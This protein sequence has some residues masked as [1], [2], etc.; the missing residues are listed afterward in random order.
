MQAGQVQ[1]R[2]GSAWPA[3]RSNAAARLMPPAPSYQPHPPLD[4]SPIKPP[5]GLTFLLIYTVW[6]ELWAFVGFGAIQLGACLG[7]I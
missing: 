4:H 3:P 6:E 5:A 1:G 7:C 2:R